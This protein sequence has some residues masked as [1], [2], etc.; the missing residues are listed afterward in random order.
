MIVSIRFRIAIARNVLESSIYASLC[1][2]KIWRGAIQRPRYRAMVVEAEEEARV[3]TK[4]AALRKRLAD[5]EMKWIKADKARIEAEK[6]AS[7]G[8]FLSDEEEKK[9]DDRTSDDKEILD[10]STQYVYALLPH[11]ILRILIRSQTNFTMPL[12]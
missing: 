1:I 11:W 5:A 6:R 2:Q 3:N 12:L 7:G 10:E 8:N 4:I 9:I